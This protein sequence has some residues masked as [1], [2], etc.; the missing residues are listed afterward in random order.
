MLPEDIEKISLSSMHSEYTEERRAAEKLHDLH[1]L[2][3]QMEQHLQ[4]EYV[5]SEDYLTLLT[6]QIPLS[7]EIKG[8]HIY[9]D[10]FYQFTPQQLL[11]IEQLLL[12]AEKITAAFTVDRSYH[13]KQPNELDLFRMTGKT[14]FQLYQLAKECGASTSEHI[15]EKNNRHLHTPDLAYLERQYEQRPVKPYQ[16]I[17]PHLTVSKSA[18][19][20]AEIEGVA[21]EILHLVR[22]EG[23]RLRDISI[24][25]RHVDDYKDTL[26]EVFRDYDIPFLLME[27]NRCSI[28]HSLN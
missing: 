14:Y 28:I 17:T 19:K 7:E 1:V 26:K 11:V 25:A 3:Q 6:E 23:L 16:E 13:D 12:H 4:D 15:L 22:E 10:G 18:S 20:R 2:Y 5:H 8:A 27:M 21:R 9:I 24:V